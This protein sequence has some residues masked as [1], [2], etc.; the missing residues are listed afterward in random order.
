V[1]VAGVYVAASRAAGTT[2][3][4]VVVVLCAEVPPGVRT[5]T[6]TLPCTFGGVRTTSLV[7]DFETILARCLPNLTTGRVPRRVPVSTMR[8]PPAVDPEVGDTPVSRGRA[9]YVK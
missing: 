5:E 3:W 1:P 8:F 6:G 2:Y 4:N 9:T 7:A